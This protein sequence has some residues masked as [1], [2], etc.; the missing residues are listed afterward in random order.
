MGNKP[1]AQQRNLA[2]DPRYAEQLKEM[3][4]LLLQ[5]QQRL[6]D[7]YRLWDQPPI[8]TYK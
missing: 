1:T 6:D 8:D 2:D 3:E 5:D 4:S 7:P